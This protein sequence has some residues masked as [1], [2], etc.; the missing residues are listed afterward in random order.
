MTGVQTCALPILPHLQS[1]VHIEIVSLCDIR[2]ERTV[3]QKKQY[4]LQCAT[5]SNIDEMLNGVP[6][7]MIVTTTDMQAH[8]EINRKALLAGRHVWSEKPMANTYAEGKELL[9][10]A[11]QKKLHLWGAPAVVN[12][13]QFSFMLKTIREGKLGKIAT[14]HGQYGHTGPT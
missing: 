14:A 9:N 3:A 10:L 11:N 4:G 8:G 2:Y 12:S 1:S 7:D 6:F 5:Y 13:P